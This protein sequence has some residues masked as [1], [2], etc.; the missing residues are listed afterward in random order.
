VG[1][2]LRRQWGDRYDLRLADMRAVKD[3]GPHETVQIDIREYAQMLEACRG[4]D[5]VVHL[6]ADKNQ[7]AEFYETLLQ[8]NIIGAYNAFHA[9]FKAGCR[10]IVF[11]SSVNAV[12]GY[13]GERPVEW[14]DPVFPVN[15]Y[16]ATKCFGEALARVYSRAHGL[17]CICVRLGVPR[18]EGHGHW[19]RNRPSFA[20][21]HRD[22]AQ[23][24]GRCVDA[25]RVDFAIVNGTSRHERMWLALEETRR[26]L[27]Y[28]PE[29]WG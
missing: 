25:E 21:S 10:R 29:D 1:T 23:L 13:N 14:H 26:V 20:I 19:H 24:F 6:A 2:I 9:A 4:M 12:L 15:V 8:L 11:A 18:E 5:T 3:P 22:M 7:D 28:E 27:G 17:S 16:G